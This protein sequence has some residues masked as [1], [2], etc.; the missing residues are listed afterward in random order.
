MQK[1]DGNFNITTFVNVFDHTT[2][3]P[4]LIFL[5]ETSVLNYDLDKI[6]AEVTN[7]IIKDEEALSSSPPLTIQILWHN[8]YFIRGEYLNDWENRPS[9]NI[10]IFH[11]KSEIKSLPGEENLYSLMSIEKCLIDSNSI[12]NSITN[13]DSIIEETFNGESSRM[14]LSLDNFIDTG[15]FI[16]YYVNLIN[17][18]ASILSLKVNNI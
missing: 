10:T 8:I 3:N 1:E 18:Y 13:W 7:S 2:N 6:L 11:R 14:D 9:K 4:Y 12:T 15:T 17:S 5:N 16:K